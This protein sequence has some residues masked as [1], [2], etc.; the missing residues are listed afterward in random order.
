MRTVTARRTRTGATVAELAIALVIASVAASIGATLLVAAERRARRDTTNGVASQTARDVS[1]AL[2]TEIAAARW[3]SLVLRTDTAIDMQAHVG[4]S[5]VCAVGPLVIVLPG[6]Q[7][8][9]GVPFTFWR[10]PPEVS[11]I[12]LVWDTA[13]AAWRETVINGVSTPADGGGCATT[14]GFRSVADSNA[15]IPVTRLH[16]ETPFAGPIGIG[17][18]VRLTRRVRWMLYRGADRQWWLGYRR[19]PVGACGAA[20]P[21]A[22]PL[23][24]PADSGLSLRLDTDATVSITLRPAGNGPSPLPTTRRLQAVRGAPRARP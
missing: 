4:L 19:C 8:S 3:D 21:V 5:V 2:G 22:G 20:Q 15:R 12:L 10:Q 18:P 23:A 6:T 14:S 9:L 7:T 24:S 11:D 1:H 13:G 17:T 16:L